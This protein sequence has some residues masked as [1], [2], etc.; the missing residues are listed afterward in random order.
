MKAADAALDDDAW[1]AT[2][3]GVDEGEDAEAVAIGRAIET[4]SMSAPGF[5]DRWQDQ[6]P[7]LL[8]YGR[9]DVVSPHMCHAA[10]GRFRRRAVRV[11]DESSH[12]HHNIDVDVV[13]RRP[14]VRA[15]D[16]ADR[17]NRSVF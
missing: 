7:F 11:F 8:T 10:A 13:P 4:K 3:E 9:F 6:V 12:V 2:G 5:R 15:I 17:L 1:R 14:S 16:L